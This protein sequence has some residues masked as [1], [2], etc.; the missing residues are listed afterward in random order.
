MALLFSAPGF[1]SV[2][3]DGITTLEDARVELNLDD[4]YTA[5]ELAEAA[6]A[7]NVEAAEEAST[8]DCRSAYARREKQLRRRTLLHALFAVPGV[9]A[10]AYI[11]LKA[12]VVL[13]GKSATATMLASSAGLVVGFYGAAVAIGV[14][15][16]IQLISYFDTRRMLGL[17]DEARANPPALD[18]KF[19]LI[20][21][22]KLANRGITTTAEKLQ[23]QIRARE[24]S[25]ELCDGTLTGRRDSKK[26]RRRLVSFHRFVKVL[27]KSDPN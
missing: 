2:P 17:I 4:Q 13:S 1:P 25:G 21:L 27:A 18:G 9:P 12:G 7:V 15:E 6:T 24:A 26:L 22:R 8:A 23:A 20:M 11:G 14:H 10:G 5:D 3:A 19:T 16:A